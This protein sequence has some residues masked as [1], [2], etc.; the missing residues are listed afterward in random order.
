MS[1][2][3]SSTI[4]FDKW[5]NVEMLFQIR[6][7]GFLKNIKRF[8]TQSSVVQDEDEIKAHMDS[9]EICMVFSCKHCNYQVAYI[10]V[11][12]GTGQRTL[13][14]YQ[15]PLAYGILPYYEVYSVHYRTTR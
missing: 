11:L 5:F 2:L 13:P 14:Y 1:T 15:V 4:D 12:S 8:T 9:H 3:T 7:S 6:G 10:T